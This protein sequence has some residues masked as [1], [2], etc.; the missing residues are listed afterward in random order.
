[1]ILNGGELNG[2]RIVSKAAVAEMTKTHSAGGKELNYGLG[3]QTGNSQRKAAPAFSAK[4]FGHGGAFGTHGL[5]DPEN[6]L[7]VVF[8]VQNVLV[9]DGGK[10]RDA[11]HQLVAE[12]LK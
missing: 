4:A 3:W 1:M 6:R 7:V 8:M 11:F 2:K 10:A 9:K 5:V 12:S